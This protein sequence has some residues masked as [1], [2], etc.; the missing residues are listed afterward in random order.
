MIYRITRK[1][2]IIKGSLTLPA[3]KSESNRALII[4]EFCDP[5]F[6]IRNLSNSLDS[7]AL[8]KIL[9]AEKA[10]SKKESVY[11]VGAAGTTMR[12]LTAYFAVKPGVRVLKGSERMHKRP[13]AVLIEALRH[14]GAGIECLE[15]EGYPPIRITGSD[16][17]GGEVTVDG[18]ISSQY[19]SALLMIAPTLP[20]GLV[21]R[22]EG[23]VASRPYINMTLKLMERFGVSG[24]WHENILSVSPQ[25]YYSLD[26][27]G[28]ITEYPI[29]AD[30]SAASYWYAMAAFSDEADLTLLGL[31]EGS[32][33][34]DSVLPHIFQFFGV[35][36]D[37][38]P[39]GGIRLTR[40]PINA[41]RF[42]FDFIDCP[43]I[44]QTIAVVS[45][46]LGIPALCRGLRTLKIK[47]TDRALAL[48][49]ELMKFGIDF[50]IK[51]D[52]AALF[53]DTKGIQTPI[54]D[55]IDTYDDHRMAMAF[56][57]LAM[58]SGSVSIRH[59]EVVSKS[60]PGFWDDMRSMGFRIEEIK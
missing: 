22:F 21:I 24:T 27:E 28:A 59:P 48:R 19:I 60:Y 56:A 36:T 31:K 34:G 30:W 3:S 53:D 57:T 35:K 47:E 39:G 26:E 23:D 6:K 15:K 42:G 29:E 46:A 1:V 37:F 2:R 58:R 32:L 49:N 12:F 8:L 41:D 18:S 45:S 16:L 4:R 14:L 54:S 9:E 5:P 11:D 17:K 25:R 40:I 52:D 10:G 13:I 51:S 43:D 33:Q 50:Q 44:A 55:A 38:L 7:R 20:L